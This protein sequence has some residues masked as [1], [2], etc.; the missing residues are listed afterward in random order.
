MVFR[1]DDP[2]VVQAAPAK[3]AKFL[4]LRDMPMPALFE[5]VVVPPKPTHHGFFGKLKGFFSSIFG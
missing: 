2:P 4:P 3:E 5:A 1:A